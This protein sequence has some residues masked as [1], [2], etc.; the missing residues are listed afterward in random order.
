MAFRREGKVAIDS[1]APGVAGSLAG[2]L[3]ELGAWCSL[4]A[5]SLIGTFL[6]RQGRNNVTTVWEKADAVLRLGY[7]NQAL[8]SYRGAGKSRKVN[9]S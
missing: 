7:S 6:G 1:A 4:S 8:Y 3:M 2:T 9:Q 5:T